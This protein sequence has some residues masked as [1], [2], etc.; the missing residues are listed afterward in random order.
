MPAGFPLWNRKAL[1]VICLIHLIGHYWPTF[2]TLEVFTSSPKT[3]YWL[4]PILAYP[5]HENDIN[6]REER[7]EVSTVVLRVS[8]FA[9]GN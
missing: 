6:P 7:E 3:Q 9:A 4:A 2:W 1:L 8:I 5:L